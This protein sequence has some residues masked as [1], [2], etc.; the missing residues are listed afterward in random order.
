MWPSTILMLAAGLLTILAGAK[1]FTNGIEWLGKKLNLSEGAVGSV[2]AAVGTAL[3]ETMVPLIAILFA[4]T[5]TATE[6]G[7][8]AILG[9]P[10]MLS[11]LAFGVVGVSKMVFCRGSGCIDVK[12]SIV[13]RDLKY[14]I[15]FYS[16]A[17]AAAFIPYMMVKIP[18]AAVLVAGY[19]YYVIKTLGDGDTL[20]ELDIPPL[21][22]WKKGGEAPLPIIII[23]VAISLCL[24]AGGAHYFVDALS[25]LATAVMMPALILSIIITPIATELPE[26]FNSIIWVK[27]GKD[28]LAMGNIT[29]AMVFQGSVIPT[30]GIML[31]PWSISTLAAISAGLALLSSIVIYLI[32]AWKRELRASHMIYPVAIYGIFLLLIFTMQ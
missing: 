32:V 31:T 11:T 5:G 8:G 20:S 26:K 4:P 25:N 3:P 17:A 6:V 1:I 7:I 21:Y 29:G 15:C 13:M 23:Q 22:L 18:I 10:F 14:F 19:G 24:I 28:T 2:L 9:A 27:G 30:I 12:R 16:L